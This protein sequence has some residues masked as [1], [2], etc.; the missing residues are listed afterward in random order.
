MIEDK[1]FMISDL[2]VQINTYK[3]ILQKVNDQLKTALSEKVKL[4]RQRNLL[5]KVVKW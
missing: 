3:N 5:K 2:L 1:D 4:A